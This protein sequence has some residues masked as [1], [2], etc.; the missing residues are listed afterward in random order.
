MDRGDEYDDY[1][2]SSTSSSSSSALYQDMLVTAVGATMGEQVSKTMISP[3]KMKFP[4]LEFSWES[5][6]R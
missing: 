6:V 2:D 1:D 4:K 5:V 3:Q